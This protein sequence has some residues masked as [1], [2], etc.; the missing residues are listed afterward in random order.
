MT[1]RPRVSSRFASPP[2]PWRHGSIP[3]FG[4]VGGIGAGK[5]AVAA[6]LEEL[7]AHVIDADKVGHALL[8]QRPVREAVIERFGY[9]I[10]D[11]STPDVAFHTI[12]RK[13]LGA[14]VFSD[15]VALRALEAILHPLMR[16][17]FEKAIDRTIRK[18]QAR[19]IVLDA[20]ILYEAGWD[21]LC[22][23]VIFIDAP[24]P[25]RLARLAATRGWDEAALAAREQRQGPLD[26]KKAR[27]D[28]VIVN[29]G[30]M[31]ALRSAIGR[32]W[33]PLQAKSSAKPRPSPFLEDAPKHAS[34]PPRR[35]R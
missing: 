20:A 18:A 27:A 35:D 1:S 15:P 34:R 24:R 10:V 32:E 23:K 9:A 12:D 13:A 31:A 8:E 7:G 30:D 6:R 28:L 14:I 29:D 11:R 22:D 25:E 21:S 2:G 16:R 4:L 26:G 33:N 5:S 3:V 17:T 19:A